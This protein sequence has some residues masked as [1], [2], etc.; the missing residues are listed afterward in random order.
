MLLQSKAVYLNKI[1]LTACR[2]EVFKQEVT[3]RTEAAL[4]LQA[5]IASQRSVQSPQLPLSFSEP[6]TFYNLK[7]NLSVRITVGIRGTR[8]GEMSAGHQLLVFG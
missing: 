2:L 8:D 6:S 3:W 4:W 5:P 7:A 1:Q